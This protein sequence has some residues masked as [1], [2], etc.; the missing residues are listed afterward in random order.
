MHSGDLFAYSVRY[1]EAH[2]NIHSVYY[3]IFYHVF[4]YNWI[5]PVFSFWCC[6][7]TESATIY[8]GPYISHNACFFRVGWNVIPS[9]SSLS[10]RSCPETSFFFPGSMLLRN[11]GSQGHWGLRG[12]RFGI[13]PLLPREVA[14]TGTWIPRERGASYARAMDAGT[15]SILWQPEEGVRLRRGE[16]GSEGHV[17]LDHHRTRGSAPRQSRCVTATAQ[18]HGQCRA[19]VARASVRRLH[20]RHKI[21]GDENDVKCWVLVGPWP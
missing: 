14:W 2:L 4:C 5:Q 18:R 12:R 3:T 1:I 10:L 21:Q 17:E 15:Q 20:L 6:E 13:G 19:N 7:Q 11:E 16:R 8:S 9:S